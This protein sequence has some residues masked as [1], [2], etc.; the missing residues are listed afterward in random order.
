M[1]YPNDIFYKLITLTVTFIVGIIFSVNVMAIEEPQY[2]LII[3]HI[4]MK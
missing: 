4:L 2:D 3:K 1:F